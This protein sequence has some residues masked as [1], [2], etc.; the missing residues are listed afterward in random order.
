MTNS[1]LVKF[2][3]LGIGGL[4]LGLLM[5]SIVSISNQEKTLSNRFKQK[6]DERSSFY[7]KMWKTLSQKSQVAVR[8][9][10]SFARN[11]GHYGG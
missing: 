6:M 1:T 2:A 7:D 3:L 11:V 5:I 10:S 9:D 4:L 8:N